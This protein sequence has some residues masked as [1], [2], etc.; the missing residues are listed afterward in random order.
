MSVPNDLARQPNSL[1]TCA[2][3]IAF[4]AHITILIAIIIVNI[5][6]VITNISIVINI[7]NIIIIIIT[8][9]IY[10]HARIN[11]FLLKKKK[12]RI[13]FTKS[14]DFQRPSVNRSVDFFSSRK[15]ILQVRKRNNIITCVCARGRRCRSRNGPL[16]AYTYT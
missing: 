2:A 4:P 16:R 12:T 3:G 9:L 8:L 14:C 5:I 10:R 11:I 7:I 15:S 1:G 13:F 6:I